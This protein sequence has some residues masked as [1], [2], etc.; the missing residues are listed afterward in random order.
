MVHL[1]KKLPFVGYR[2]ATRYWRAC[3][4]YRYGCCVGHIVWHSAR[5][6]YSFGEMIQ[7]VSRFWNRCKSH[8]DEETVIF[9]EYYRINGVAQ[10]RLHSRLQLWACYGHTYGVDVNFLWDV[11]YNELCV[12][13]YLYASQCN[14]VYCYSVQWL[15]H[16]YVFDAIRYLPTH[17]N[18]HAH[19]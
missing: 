16:I 3:Y 18:T 12:I 13:M 4:G 1:I 11:L 2:H 15:V 19:A 10:R 6:W 8:W 14:F 9:M 5:W 7:N 17:T